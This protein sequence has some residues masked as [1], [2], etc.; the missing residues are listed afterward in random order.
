MSFFLCFLFFLISSFSFPSLCISYFLVPRSLRGLLASG[1]SFVASV[2][3]NALTKLDLRFMQ[4]VGVGTPRANEE[5]AK[6]R[7]RGE[8]E[9]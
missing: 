5:V 6:V 2:L 9:L 3:A 4:A 7:R 1:D 8:K